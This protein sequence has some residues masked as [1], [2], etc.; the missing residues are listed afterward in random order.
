MSNVKRDITALLREDQHQ[1][2]AESHSGLRVV[3]IDWRTDPRWE[4]FISAQPNSMIYQ[5]PAWLQVL[6]EAYSYHSASLAC[7]DTN[8]ELR[9]ILPLCYMEGLFTGRRLV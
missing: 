3:E 5:H 6:E 8:G 1:N 4:A 2:V 9:A 7:E